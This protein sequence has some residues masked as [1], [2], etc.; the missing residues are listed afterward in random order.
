MITKEP[1]YLNNIKKII[2]NIIGL[3]KFMN[4]LKIHK[5]KIIICLSNKW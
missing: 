4:K 1:K 3:K 2:I 5:R